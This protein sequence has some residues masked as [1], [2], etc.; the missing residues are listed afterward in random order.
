MANLNNTDGFTTQGWMVKDL[1][2]T[3]Y[4][5]VIF[6]IINQFSQSKEGLYK[7][8]VSYLCEWTGISKISVRKHLRK[9]EENGLIKSERGSINNIQFCYYSTDGVG[10]KVTHPVGKK[11]THGRKESYPGG[12]KESYRGVGKKVTPDN[13]GENNNRINKGKYT[14]DFRSA[15]VGLGIQAQLVDDY[16][17]VRKNRKLSQTKTAFDGILK[18]LDKAKQMGFSY[19]ESVRITVEHSWGGIKAE[20]IT[21]DNPPAYSRPSD[22]RNTGITFDL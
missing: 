16:I 17:T 10:K 11:V 8:G 19:D 12:R 21:R 7:G 6:A 13:K 2:L 3:G 15:L 22:N 1:G 5:L 9:L 14:F 20:W 18:E 4:D